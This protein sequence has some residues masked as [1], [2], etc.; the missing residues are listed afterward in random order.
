MKRVEN[1]NKSE[2]ILR[3]GF[4]LEVSVGN[5]KSGRHGLDAESKQSSSMPNATVLNFNI[6][7]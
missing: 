2:N 5:E 4:P 1:A 3:D 7:R 6:P